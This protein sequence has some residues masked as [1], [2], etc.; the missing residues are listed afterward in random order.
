MSPRDEAGLARNARRRRGVEPL[1]EDATTPGPAH[2]G[3]A[4]RPDLVTRARMGEEDAVAELLAAHQDA[5]YTLALRLVGDRDLAADVAQE[6]LVRAWRAL[7]GF[8]GDARFSTWLYRITVNT[9]RSVHKRWA[10][11]PTSDLAA[12]PEP[13]AG[14]ATDPEAVGMDADLA[15][16]ISK[17]LGRISPRLRAVVVLKDMYDW[18]HPEIAA[19]LGIT[20]TAA[21]VRLHRGRAALRAV[22][23]D[24]LVEP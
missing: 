9:A 7:P 17:A 13:E 4:G 23:E 22:L 15:Q 10:R 16:R 19:H 5:V 6:A 24:E 8:R 11:F 1:D 12:T 3:E 14:P 18:S 21:K 20:V 2:T